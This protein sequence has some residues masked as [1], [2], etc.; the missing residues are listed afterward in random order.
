M[1]FA[2]QAR[3]WVRHIER[4]ESDRSGLPIKSSRPAVAR[5][6]GTTASA[7]EHVSRGRAKRISAH[8]FAAIQRAFI[9]RTYCDHFKG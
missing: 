9:G 2:F 5:R 1:S 6:I 8:L 3:E 7:V 4:R